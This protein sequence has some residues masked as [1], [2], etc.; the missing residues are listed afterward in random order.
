M[1]IPKYLQKGDTIGVTATSDGIVNELKKKRVE[2]AMRQLSDRGY[3]VIATDNLFKSDARGCS[4]TGAER[5]KEINELIHNPNVRSI[6]SAAGGDYCMEML[7]YIDFEYLSKNPKWFQGFSDNT[8]IVYPLVTKYDT[9]AVYGC[10]VGDF[11]M[12]PWQ[13]PVEDALGV[14]EGTTRKLYSYDYFEDERHEYISGYEGYCADKE[15]KWIN[16]RMEDEISI[17]GRLIGGCL[18]VIVFLLGTSYD[19]TE[20]FVNKYK[21]DGIIWNLESFNMEDT[22]IITHLWQMKEKGYFKYANG[23]IF[24]RPL[25]YNSWSNRTYE[26]AV[27]WVLGDLDVPIIFNSDI[28]HKGPQ[29]PIIEGAKAKIISSNGKGI[30]EYI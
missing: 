12:K 16:G 19:G 1:N 15:V 18:D 29:F 30:L 22:T 3:N 27:M 4:G 28:G 2:N 23:F 20:E 10:H 7:E 24:G 21:S 26:D 13:K 17:T 11:G 6:M 5:G 9:A 8:C 25:M 14:I